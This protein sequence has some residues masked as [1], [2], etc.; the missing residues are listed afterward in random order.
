MK[1]Y[2]EGELLTAPL[3]LTSLPYSHPSRH[4]NEELV[5]SPPSNKLCNPNGI[6][7]ERPGEEERKGVKIVTWMESMK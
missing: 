3:P 2:D 1:L 7:I 5:V 6:S 4:H